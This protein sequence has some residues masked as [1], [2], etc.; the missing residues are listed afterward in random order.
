MELSR[1][2]RFVLEI[3]AAIE[4]L[5]GDADA[6]RPAQRSQDV[7]PQLLQEVIG[8]DAIEAAE[9]MRLRQTNVA[10]GRPLRARTL[11]APKLEPG[12]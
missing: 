11:R 4:I 2:A 9:M 5:A 10:I 12:P 3:G 8:S 1:L 6:Q 7:Q